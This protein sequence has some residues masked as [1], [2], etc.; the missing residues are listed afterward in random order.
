MV[1]F[2]IKLQTL[3]KESFGLFFAFGSADSTKWT[4]CPSRSVRQCFALL[5]R[6]LTNPWNAWTRAIWSEFSLESL[7]SEGSSLSD[8]NEQVSSA[9][10]SEQVDQEEEGVL[11]VI[12][13]SRIDEKSFYYKVCTALRQGLRWLCNVSHME[14]QSFFETQNIKCS[15][16][17]VTALG[18][19]G[20]KCPAGGSVL[21]FYYKF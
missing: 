1:I 16:A 4:I 3:A 5:F 17:A 12:T 19:G 2:R 15:R 21:F 11:F 9:L 10:A 7:T 20:S 18:Q 14:D 13:R 8:V 6:L